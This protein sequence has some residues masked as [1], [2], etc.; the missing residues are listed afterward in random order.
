MRPI[1]D[2]RLTVSRSSRTCELMC[3]VCLTSAL[4][5]MLAGCSATQVSEAPWQSAPDGQWAT[6]IVR[7][8]T[9]GPGN[10]SLT[11]TV[12]VKREGANGPVDVVSLDEQEGPAVIKLR[13]LDAKHLQV[14]HARGRV[15]L[16]VVRVGDLAIETVT[17]P[18]G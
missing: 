12:Q 15:V 4:V 5:G 3:R 10:N 1:A 16:Q 9:S 7:R 2:I 14:S 6:R 17:L 13:W 11:E 18:E 8:D